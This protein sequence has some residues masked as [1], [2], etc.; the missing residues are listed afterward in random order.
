[1]TALHI[2]ARSALLFIAVATSSLAASTPTVLEPLFRSQPAVAH[3]LSEVDPAVRRLL[4]RRF[5]DDR[6]IADYGAE[7]DPGCTGGTGALPSRRFALAVYIGDRWFV[8]Y[9]HG[10]RGRHSHLVVFSRSGTSWRT[11]YSGVGFYEY[12]TLPKLRRAITQGEYR[13]QAVDA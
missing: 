12:Y 13:Q 7:F 11:V 6:R 5:D 2:F 4:L 1:M 8:E 10:G 9:E 3:R